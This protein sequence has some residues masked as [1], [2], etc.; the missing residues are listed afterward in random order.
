[1]NSDNESIESVTMYD[2]R[3]DSNKSKFYFRKK[4]STD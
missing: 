4:L 2:I 1:M 3:D